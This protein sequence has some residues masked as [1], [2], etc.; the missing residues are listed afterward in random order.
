MTKT[1][2][3]MAMGD[4]GMALYFGLHWTM[5]DTASWLIRKD[6]NMGHIR[7]KQPGVRYITFNRGF[8][9]K[10]QALLLYSKEVWLPLTV[11]DQVIESQTNWR[12]FSVSF[13]NTDIINDPE[14]YGHPRLA[15]AADLDIVDKWIEAFF[16]Y[17]RHQLLCEPPTTDRGRKFDVWHYR[18]QVEG[19]TWLPRKVSCVIPES[20]FAAAGWISYRRSQEMRREFVAL[21]RFTQEQ[22]NDSQSNASQ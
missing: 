17:Q 20:E 10:T 7:A 8:H 9:D 4:G 21:N 6:Q 2:P 1:P 14:H 19:P 16:G 13:H 11:G 12:H 3:A 5:R 22:S 18:L 15:T